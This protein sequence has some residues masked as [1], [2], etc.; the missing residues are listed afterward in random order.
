MG[1]PKTC[2]GDQ[3]HDYQAVFNVIACLQRV[4]P[5]VESLSHLRAKTDRE[6]Q[7]RTELKKVSPHVTLSMPLALSVRGERKLPIQYT[8]TCA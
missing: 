7:K 2:S 3:S 6:K 5:E 4:I 8:A 1:Q